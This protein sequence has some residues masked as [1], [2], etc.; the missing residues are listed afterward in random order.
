MDLRQTETIRAVDDDGV[1]RRHVDAA[2]DDGGTDQN[3]EPPMIEIEHE[4][5]Q[6][7]LAH[8]AVPD[9]DIRLGHEL[10]NGL[11]R[12]LDGLDGV[13]DEVYLP[14]AP[15]LAQARLAPH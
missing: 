14:A 6:I 12:F 8:L 10:A 3:I 9:R 7:A 2:L 5:L 1:G 4:L 13:V 11:G 15:N